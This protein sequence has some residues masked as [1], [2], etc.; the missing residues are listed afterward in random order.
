MSQ[1]Q[2][3]LEKLIACPSITP[4]DAGCQQLIQSMLNDL[5]F[6][7]EPMRFGE[8]DNL[9]A[10]KGNTAP[11][12]VFMGHT[13][14]VPPGPD[15]DWHSPPF[16]ATTRDGFLYG[17]G[18]CDMKGAIAA[19]LAAT[20]RFVD[21][22]H[23]FNG[24]IGYLL[25]SD[26]EGPSIDGT[27][28]VITK[29]VER[30]IQIQYAIV[31]E[32]SSDQQIGDQIRIGRRGSLHGKLII[33]GKQGHVAYPSLADNPIHRS[34]NM[35]HELSQTEWDQ[36]NEFFPATS[37]QITN[38]NAGT[39]ALNVIPGHVDVAF[40]FRYSTAITIEQLIARTNEILH[41]A[42]L[43]YDLD[44]NIGAEPFLTKRGSLITDVISIIKDV[45]GCDTNLSTGGGTSDARFVAPTGA[46]VI[47]LGLQHATAHQAN[48]CISL[49]SLEQLTTIYYQVLNQLL[50][51]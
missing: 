28:Q 25:T 29:L 35:L 40:N 42:G 48:E 14:V 17:R 1:A 51:R 44:W 41:K 6:Q 36:G 45:T 26:E 3:I 39:G 8:V 15:A 49:T 47:E 37:F 22:H 19:M 34:M 13:D 11:L 16:V 30:G 2:S 20:K 27:R 10:T 7:C 24:T 43:H 31:G 4:N 50:A 18:A 32:P 21:E 46:E 33:H 23:H 9:W 5:Q 38:M 12:V